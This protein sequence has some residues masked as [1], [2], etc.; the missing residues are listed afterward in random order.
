MPLLGVLVLGALLGGAVWGAIWVY[1]YVKEND[2]GPATADLPGIKDTEQSNYRYLL[3]GGSWKPNPEVTAKMVVNFCLSRNK[4]NNNLAV[5]C[6][7]YTRRLPSEGEMI[8]TALTKL[9]SLLSPLE[10]ERKPKSSIKLGNQP[11]AVHLEFQGT[12][13][14]GIEMNGEVLVIGYQG[15][16]YWFF[17]WCPAEQIETLASEWIK[18]RDNFTLLNQKES[19][20]ETPRP[21]D[22]IGIPEIPYEVAFVKEVWKVQPPLKAADPNARVFL[23]GNDPGGP[24][25]ASKAAHFRLVLLDKAPGPK[26]AFDAA[27]KYVLEKEKEEYS[28]TV[29]TPTK[30]KDG[31]DQIS[32]TDIGDERGWLGKFQVRNTDARERYLVLATVAGTE[33]TLVLLCD[34]DYGRKDFWDTEFAELIKSFKK[35]KD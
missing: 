16:G 12:N 1:N 22:T 8:D 19:W 28:E 13:P 6:R 11:V 33:N 23:L 3:P 20:K 5:F 26:E 15:R 24:I 29:I 4:P 17:T 10:W 18:L 30:N 21:R 7:D 34:C 2:T 9:R 35:K 31:K 14:H 32:L 27:Q 25:H